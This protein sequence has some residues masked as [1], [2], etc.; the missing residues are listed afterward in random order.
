MLKTEQVVNITH[1]PEYK[2]EPAR[3]VLDTLGGNQYTM[4]IDTYTYSDNTFTHTLR[5]EPS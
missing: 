3:L 1:F 2:K 5:L 4:F